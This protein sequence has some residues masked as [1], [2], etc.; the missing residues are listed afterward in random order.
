MPGAHRVGGHGG[1]RRGRRD[2]RGPARPRRAASPSTTSAPSTPRSPTSSA[3]PSRSSR[4]TSRSWTASAREDSADATLIATIV[5]MAQA[6]GHHHRRR[7]RGDARCRPTGCVELGCD[8]VQGYLYS[9]PVGADRLPEVVA[10]LGTQRLRLVQL[11]PA[12]PRRRAR[13]RSDVRPVRRRRGRRGAAAGSSP[14]PRT[15]IACRSGSSAARRRSASS[16][17]HQAGDGWRRD[18]RYGTRAEALVAGEDHAQ[19]PAHDPEHRHVEDG[20][21][22]VDAAVEGRERELWYRPMVTRPLRRLAAGS[23][24]ATARVA[25]SQVHATSR[26][27]PVRSM[28]RPGRLAPHGC[29]VVEA[30]EAPPARA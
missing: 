14:S 27:S 20:D 7:G 28:R 4:S 10:S 5:A 25:M 8:A 21:E 11:T 30:L 19:L 29:D 12:G 1:P 15:R 18:P 23:P 26:S 22:P 16:T 3:S 6:L 2:P 17:S 9:R 13:R 24:P